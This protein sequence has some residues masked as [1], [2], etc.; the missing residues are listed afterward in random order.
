MTLGGQVGDKWV[1]DGC[2]LSG[3]C[4]FW[5]FVAFE[6]VALVVLKC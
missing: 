3:L 5:L 1:G 2:L 4:G 6:W